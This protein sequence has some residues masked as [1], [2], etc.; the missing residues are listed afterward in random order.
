[1]HHTHT[2]EN[3]PMQKQVTRG[4]NIVADGWAEASNPHPH[5]NPPPTLKHTQKVS[6]TLVFTLFYPI[7]MTDGPTDQRT[8]PLIELRVLN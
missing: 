4:H 5:P 3:D 8:K 1:M 6:E 7:T 2:K